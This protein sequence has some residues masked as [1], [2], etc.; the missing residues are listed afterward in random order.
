MTTKVSIYEHDWARL[1]EDE[2]VMLFEHRPFIVKKE[3]WGEHQFFFDMYIEEHEPK[4]YEKYRL[5]LE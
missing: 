4:F 2:K 5:L 1:D 3:M